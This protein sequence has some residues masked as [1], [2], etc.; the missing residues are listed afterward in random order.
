MRSASVLLPS[1]NPLAALPLQMQPFCQ[2]CD[3]YHLYLRLRLL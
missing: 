1:D 3:W 2:K